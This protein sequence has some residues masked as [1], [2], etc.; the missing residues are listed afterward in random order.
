MGPRAGL[1]GCGNHA[2]T[3]IRSPDR[4]VRSESL[5]RLSYIIFYFYKLTKTNLE[6]IIKYK[7]QDIVTVIKFRSLELL[8]HVI[9]MNETRFV[10]KIFEGN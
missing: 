4:P 1:E 10:K 5:Y 7:S 6:L 8:G 3:G 9:R 2:P